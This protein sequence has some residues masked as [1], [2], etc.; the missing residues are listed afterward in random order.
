MSKYLCSRYDISLFGLTGFFIEL[1][2]FM[3][4]VVSA[5]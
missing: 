1:V 5:G 3:F 2:L 4:V